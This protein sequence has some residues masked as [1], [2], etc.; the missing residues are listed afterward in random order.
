M[1]LGDVTVLD[2][3]PPRLSDKIPIILAKTG[4]T[5][6]EAGKQTGPDRN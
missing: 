3:P 5:V 1:V 4:V 6:M 2:V